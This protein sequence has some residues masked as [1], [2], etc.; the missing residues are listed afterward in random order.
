[1]A[2]RV[3]R[4]LLLTSAI[5]MLSGNRDSLRVRNWRWTW[6]LMPLETRDVAT[7]SV[8]RPTATPKILKLIERNKVAI[9]ARRP[10]QN[11]YRC[12]PGG[13]T[14]GKPGGS[15]FGKPGGSTFGFNALGLPAPGL[16]APGFDPPATLFSAEVATSLEATPSS[17]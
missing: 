6:L 14:F 5:V 17:V 9:P 12:K 15:T 3:S 2:S 13:S 16:P 1:M 10:R 7:I 11:H 4:A 8:S